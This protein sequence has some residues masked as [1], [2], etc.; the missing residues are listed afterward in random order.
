METTST[1]GVQ[2]YQSQDFLLGPCIHIDY[3][4]YV[5]GSTNHRNGPKCTG[6]DRNGTKWMGMDRNGTNLN[7]FI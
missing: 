4:I 1:I 7:F 2:I 3:A 5:M 6:M